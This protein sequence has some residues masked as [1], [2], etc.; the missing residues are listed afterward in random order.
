FIFDR[1]NREELP[2]TAG[3]Y[4]GNEDLSQ[5]YDWTALVLESPAGADA[6]DPRYKM[7]AVYNPGFSGRFMIKYSF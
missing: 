4:L 5:G 2:D 1:Y 3:A 7:D 6:L